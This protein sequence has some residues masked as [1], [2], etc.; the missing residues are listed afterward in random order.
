M[1]TTTIRIDLPPVGELETSGDGRSP[2]DAQMAE[3]TKARQDFL[4][5]LSPYVAEVLSRPL[6]RAGNVTHVQLLGGD[7]WSQLNHYLLLVTTD[8]AAPRFAGELLALLPEGSQASD[9]GAFGPLQEWPA[10]HSK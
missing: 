10:P 5:I 6:R 3:E 9:L 1:A 7:V 2:T 4:D 8:S